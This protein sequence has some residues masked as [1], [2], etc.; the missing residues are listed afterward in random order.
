LEKLHEP[1]KKRF[2]NVDCIKEMANLRSNKTGLS[3]G[4]IY[5]STKEGNHGP[6]VK[7]YRDRPG[8]NKSVSI[9]ISKNPKVVED[10]INI[11][12]Q[13]QKEVFEFVKLNYNKLIDFWNNGNS[14]YS[15]EVD[16]FLK[17]LEKI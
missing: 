8:V 17:N 4:T 1:Y 10:S 2:S 16:I 5:I 11:T 7:F 12:A 9:N 6:R 15:D 14:W 3:H 13:E